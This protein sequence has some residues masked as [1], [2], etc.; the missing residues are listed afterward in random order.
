VGHPSGNS[1]PFQ[2]Y[3]TGQFR[4][5]SGKA[6]LYN[7]ALK[8]QGLDPVAAFVPPDES[9][10]SSAAKAYPLEMLARKVDNFLNSTFTNLP[11]LR[12]MEEFGILEMTE[13][14]AKP[15]GIHDG[16]RVRVFNSRGEIELRARVNGAVPTGVVSARLNWA[17]LTPGGRNINVLTSEKLS[18]MGNSATFYSVLVEV[19]LFRS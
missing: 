13:A 14:D 2:P 3:A 6:L 11:S 1:E 4:T 18:D 12:S 5:P 9:R 10:H 16:D 15:R 19:E 17:K 8:A 7:E